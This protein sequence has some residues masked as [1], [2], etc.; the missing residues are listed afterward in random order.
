[1]SALLLTKSNREYFVSD[2]DYEDEDDYE[3]ELT[4][5]PVKEKT[6]II[7]KDGVVIGKEK[8]KIK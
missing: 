5:E 6:V 4:E 3:F 1:M 2:D 7:K 8:I